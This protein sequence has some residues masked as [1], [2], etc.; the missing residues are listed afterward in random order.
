MRSNGR[1]DPFLA[2]WSLAVVATTAAFVVHLAIRVKTVELGYELGEA[3]AHVARLREVRRVL[4]V[5]LA[6]YKTPERVERVARSLLG[7]TE[8]SAD[9]IIFAG[10][11]PRVSEGDDGWNAPADRSTR[12]GAGNAPRVS[13]QQEEDGR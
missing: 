2:L 6:S 8:P 1:R 4:E 9:R 12:H 10:P 3:H 5:E 13:R 7:M 11:V